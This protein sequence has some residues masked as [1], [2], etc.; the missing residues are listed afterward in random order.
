[1]EELQT[2]IQIT[3]SV[4]AYS[5]LFS[6]ASQLISTPAPR[7]RYPTTSSTLHTAAIHPISPYHPRA[8]N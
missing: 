2:V 4:S 6:D 5:S 7:Y 3:S 8:S 1:V